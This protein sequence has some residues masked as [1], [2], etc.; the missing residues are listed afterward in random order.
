M[1]SFQ[2][3]QAARIA[4]AIYVQIV[5]TALSS[6]GLVV[7]FHAA[8]QAA[9]AAG[10]AYATTSSGSAKSPVTKPLNI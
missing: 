9:R 3:D 10:K 2:H 1:N 6:P 5:G 7:D 8:D 4:E